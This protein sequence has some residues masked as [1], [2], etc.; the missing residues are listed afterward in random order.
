L[1]RFGIGK[2]DEQKTGV[3]ERKE[4]DKGKRE[5]KEKGSKEK[6]RKKGTKKR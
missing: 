3:K 2:G 5:D 4:K 6:I 1:P